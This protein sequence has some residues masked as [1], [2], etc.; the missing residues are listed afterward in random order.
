MKSTSMW[1]GCYVGVASAGPGVE[2]DPQTKIF[3]HMCG[4]DPQPVGERLNLSTPSKS[5]T[6]HGKRRSVSL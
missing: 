6:A 3:S 4:D 5:N 2:A 1:P